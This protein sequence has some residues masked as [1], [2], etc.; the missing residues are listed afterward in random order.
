MQNMLLRSSISDA[1]TTWKLRNSYK[2]KD[3]RQVLG[4]TLTK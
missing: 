3:Y 2:Q 1:R 4:V